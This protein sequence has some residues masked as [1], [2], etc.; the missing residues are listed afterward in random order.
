MP[1]YEACFL[2]PLCAPCLDQTHAEKTSDGSGS[3]LLCDFSPLLYHLF[4]RA[5]LLYQ[6]LEYCS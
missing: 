6:L 5:P 3:A 1:T 2:S 4:P